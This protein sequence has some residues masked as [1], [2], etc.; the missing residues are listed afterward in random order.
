MEWP[1]GNQIQ[2]GD[3][4]GSIYLITRDGDLLW[5]GD[6]H[7]NGTP[8]WATN[9]GNR[10][11]W[12][13][14]DVRLA[15]SGGDGIIYAI[16]EN[17]DLHWYQDVPRNGTIG[18]AA[19][20]G[21]R[22]GSGWHDVRLAFA[23][24][25]GTI[26]AIKSNG[27]LLWFR[28][29]PRNGTPGW[30]Q[31]SGN[32]I[33]SGWQDSRF[34]ISG[35]DGIIYAIKENGDLHWYRDVPRDGNPGWA[36]NSGN[37]IGSGWQTVQDVISG[38]GGIIYAIDAIGRLLWYRDLHRDGTPGW[39]PRSGEAIGSGWTAAEWNPSLAEFGHL[40]I[41]QQGKPAFGPRRLLIVLVEYDNDAADNFP[42]YSAMHPLE[43]Y[44]KLG[45]GA[46][47][48]PFAT[49]GPVNPASLTEYFR[50]CSLGRFW[51]TRVDMAGPISMGPLV[52]PGPEARSQRILARI[53]EFEPKIF[54]D[55]DEDGNAIV[56]PSEFLVLVVENFRAL[57]PANRDNLAVEVRINVGIAQVTKTI[58]LHVAFAGPLTPFYQIAHETS[59]SIGTVDLY[60]SGAG[61]SLLTLMGGYSFFS[62]DQG[63]VHLDA[64]HKLALG[65]CEPR[66]R[67]LT[68]AGDEQLAEISSVEPNGAIILWHP[69]R[70]AGE[71]FIVERRTARGQRKYDG[72]F[73]G[74]GALVWRITRGA[75]P[76]THLGAP[77]CVIG[78]NTVW[79]AGMQ[80]PPL[81]WSDNTST[82]I[83][84]AFTRGLGNNLRVTWS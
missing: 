59:H 83:S 82:G 20:S 6:A 19:N 10:I 9:S 53:A 73:P 18:W 80:T 29:V 62:N 76:A 71:Y 31:N 67:K 54:F 79:Q 68:R 33:G 58:R 38:D 14:Q 5:Y 25:N 2:F 1:M 37:S 78:G 81:P 21:N 45:F 22:I 40:S 15:F 36:A 48:P 12:G 57:Q 56:T 26:Y 69:D 50:E 47:N 34:A 28:D 65:W 51:L 42:P 11:G 77:N 43:Y 70:G 17:G 61:N 63:S 27:D 30:A 74:D 55:A 41:L 23:G 52:D 39:A 72:S 75:N 16:K 49:S 7:R 66:R 32:R 4:S 24:G 60:N 3:S 35:G 44:E 64:W 8:G 13:W 46:P 84:L